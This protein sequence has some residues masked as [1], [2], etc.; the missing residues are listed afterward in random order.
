M[1]VVLLGPPGAGKGTQSQ[2][3]A[4][5]LGIPKVATGDIFRDAIARGTPLGLEAKPY[6]DNGKLVPDRITNE[7]VRERLTRADCARGAVLDGYPR[8]LDQA[9]Q[10]DRMLEDLCGG[11]SAVVNID[12]STDVLL[13]RMSGRW[14]C[15]RC[16]QTFHELF[17]PPRAA[18]ACDRCGGE[19]YQ[20]P[21]DSLDVA[22]SRLDVYANRTEPVIAYYREKALLADVDG[23]QS[24]DAVLDDILAV[25]NGRRKNGRRQD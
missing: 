3:L 21:D 9:R 6:L 8:T 20:R 24:P 2:R 19:L 16:Q 25:L 14:T 13:R 11:I 1:L 12:V 23:E 10:F 15:R 17:K 18:G 22:R 4:E 5:R 7:M